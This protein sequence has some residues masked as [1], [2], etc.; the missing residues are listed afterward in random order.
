MDGF[1]QRIIGALII[2]SLAVIFL[3]MLL[4]E[5]HQARREQTLEVPPEPEME[6]VEAQQP[7]EPQVPESEEAP[8]IPMADEGEVE[9]DGTREES[10]TVTRNES[11]PESESELATGST[12]E[13]EQE[14]SGALRGAWLVR[15][16]SF[17]NRDN[18][19]KLRDS[20]RDQ[21][22]DAHSETVDNDSGTFT[23][24][25]AGPFVDEQKAETAMEE[26]ESEFNLEAMVVEGEE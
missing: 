26:L 6:P 16:G 15:L 20:V 14:E 4:D 25:F 10:A 22:M 17:S 12:P 21:G 24:V 7:R 1:K 5:P 13:V 23:R 8:E 3:P 11:E 2:V 9:R 19:L 18:A